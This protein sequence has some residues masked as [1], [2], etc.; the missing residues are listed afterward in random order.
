MRLSTAQVDEVVRSVLDVTLRLDANEL[1]RSAELDPQP[2]M[3][4]AQV[5][6]NGEWKGQV[7]MYVSP[8]LAREIAAVM[9]RSAPEDMGREEAFDAVGELTNMIA[10]NLRPLI[11]GSRSLSLPKVTE[12]GVGPTAL[13]DKQVELSY[14]LDGRRLCVS[15]G[16]SSTNSLN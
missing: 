14:R 13:P 11:L 1:R 6:L 8:D 9:M 2:M 3:V 15:V 16:G 5:N 12:Q 10:G 4:R 7:Q